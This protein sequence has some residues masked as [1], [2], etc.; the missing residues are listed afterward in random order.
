MVS[1]D[2]EGAFNNAWWPAM[3][4]Q[5]L[6]YNCQV[7]LYGLVRGYLRDQEVFANNVVLM[8]SGQSASSIEEKA[9]RAL[10][11]VHCWGVKNKL[12][13]AP[14]KTNSMVLTK[15][16]KYDDPAV[17]MNGKQI[18]L[19]GE[20]RLLVLTIDRKLTFIPKV[21][22]ACKKATNIYKGLA[23]VA[24]ATWDLSPEVI[25]TIYTTV[26][27][28]IVLYASCVW[29]PA[30]GKLGVQKMVDAVQRSVALK[31]C[32]VHRTVL[33]IGYESISDLDSQTM[34]RL[35]V[36]GLLI[37]TDGSRTKAKS[38]RADVLH[39]LEDCDYVPSGVCS[40]RIG[41]RRSDCEAKL[42]GDHGKNSKEK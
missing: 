9:N 40:D 22:K 3:R 30:T 6:A 28:P 41:D 21:A 38:V 15:K 1:L 4:T 29:V 5:L 10:A 13:L 32:R 17:H 2:I 36:D 27:E 24:K 8:F 18:S 20:I 14:L 35:E 12:R 34:D 16:L 23:R 33:E 31:S 7:N 37:Y 39:V 42:S 19:V 11:H 25:R 26:I